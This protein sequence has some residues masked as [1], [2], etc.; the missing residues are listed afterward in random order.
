MVQVPRRSCLVGL[1]SAAVALAQGQVDKALRYRLAADPHRPQFH[2]LPPAHWM[3]DPNGPIFWKGRY[4]MFYQHNPNG[5]FWGTMHWGHAVSEDLVHWKH[6]P[7]A[8]APTPG[9]PDKDGCFTGCA[10]DHN[11]VPTLVYTGVRPEVQ[12][13]AVSDADMIVWKK[14]AGNPVIASPPEGLRATGFRDPCVW[15]QGETWY[16][17]IGSGFEGVGGTALLYHS[18]NLIDWTYMHPLCVGTM[19]KSA[20]GKGPVATGEMWECPDFFPLGDK[21]VLIVSTRGTTPYFVGRY[22]NHEFHPETEG[23]ID[24]G[25]YYAPK[26]L[27]DGRGRR[28]LWGWVRERRS[29]EAQKAAG[30]SGVF[31]LPRILSLDHHGRLKMEPAPEVATLRGRHRRRRGVP[32]VPSGSSLLGGLPGDCLEIL[33]EIESS[34]VTGLKLLARSAPDATEQTLLSSRIDPGETFKLRIF[35]DG[36]VIEVFADETICVSGRMYPSRSDAIDLALVG[37]EGAGRVKI[38]DIWEMQPISPDRMT[39]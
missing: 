8:L 2:L 12:C 28:I 14:Y 15:R 3:N 34:D 4:H 20:K 9:G 36:S 24:H 21:H 6:L 26:S 18:K 39:T 1:A 33:A 27:V 17:L 13:I 32:I 23:V 22:E 19:D 10:V 5:A 30:W 37:R 16:M 29:Q 35:V 25:A 11:G 31:S 38:L 7:I